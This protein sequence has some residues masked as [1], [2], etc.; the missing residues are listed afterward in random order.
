MLKKWSK[1]MACLSMVALTMTTLLA[2][3]NGLDTGTPS[4]NS[5]QANPGQPTNVSAPPPPMTPTTLQLLQATNESPNSSKANLAVSTGR[6]WNLR[7]TDILTLI[8]EVSRET[9]KNFIVDPRVSG[10]VTIIST[11]PIPPAELYHVFLSVLQVNGYATV[12]V[13]PAIK[14]V[15][16]SDANA[17]GTTVTSGPRPSLGETIVVRVLPVKYITA[18]QLV[19]ILRNLLPSWASISVYAPS[20]TLII[21]GSATSVDKIAKIVSQIDSRNAGGI[22]MIPLKHATASEVV[23]TLNNLENSLRAGGQRADAW[24]VADQRTNSVLLSGSLETRLRMQMLIAQLDTPNASSATID[25]QV[26]FLHYLNAVKFAPTLMKIAQGKASITAA[27]GAGG[28]KSATGTTETTPAAGTPIAT[29][30]DNTYG[31][32]TSSE[33]SDLNIQSDASANALI[34]TAPAALMKRLRKVITRLDVRPAQVLVQAAIVE[35]DDDE[36]RKFGVQWGSIPADVQDGSASPINQFEFGVGIINS[37]TW[38]FLISALQQNTKT[39]ILSTPTVVVLD[40]Q[41]ADLSVG[42]QV[43]IQTGSYATTGS[44]ATAT[45]FTTTD[46]QNFALELSV[47]PQITI[48]K[49]VQLQIVQTDNSLQNPTNPSSNPVSNVSKIKTSVIVN[50]GDILVLGGLISNSVI[51]ETSK[52]PFIGDIPLIGRLLSFKGHTKNKKNLMVFLHPVILHSPED[53]DAVTKGRYNYMRQLQ[54]DVTP[55]NAKDKNL[56]PE[57]KDYHEIPAPF[58]NDCGDMNGRP[59]CG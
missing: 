15:P 14:I 50:S 56:L 46:R 55:A 41:K 5:N 20:N 53:N 44:A 13:G 29:P 32:A 11:K 37:G 40:N 39:N 58:N 1:W 33:S 48:G 59:D 57:W 49:A 23:V 4:Q 6:L 19:P 36:L 31:N 54:L 9:G 26:V 51:E 43:G 30:V 18:E 25:T 2:N 16:N 22:E 34:I 21:G 38:Q 7:N 47:V 45:P 8:D 28:E 35:I 3:G 17:Q 52:T 27:G 12:P 24:F 10:K 42:E